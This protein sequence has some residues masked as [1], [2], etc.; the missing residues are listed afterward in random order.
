MGRYLLVA[1]IAMIACAGTV[2]A[3]PDHAGHGKSRPDVVDEGPVGYG[4]GGCPPGLRKKNPECMPPG[5]YK[6]Q[7]EIG[8]RVPKGY[9]GLRSYNS[10]PYEMRM[11][12]GGALDPQARYI[13][14]QN[15]LY[16]VDPATMVVRQILRSIL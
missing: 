1:G 13:Y 4:V 14:D 16:R 6:K 12:Y 11:R 5:Q 2:S 8:Q 3:K 15:Y 10:L 9:D 7:F